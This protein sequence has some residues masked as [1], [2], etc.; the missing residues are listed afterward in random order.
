MPWK[1]S[2]DMMKDIDKLPRGAGWTVQAMQIEGAKGKKEIVELWKQNALEI[3][4][5]LLR[6][7][8]LSK[9][10][11]FKPHIK[12][13]SLEKTERIRD[14]MYTADLMWQLQVSKIT[15]CNAYKIT[16]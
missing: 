6:N 3:V 11:N 14:E 8:R 5:Q 10:I 13:T 16:T 4:K 12:W 7:K 1:T 2:R 15:R 9:H